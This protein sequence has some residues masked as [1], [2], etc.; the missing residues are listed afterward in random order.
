MVSGF[1]TS[2]FDHVRIWSAVASA[3]DSWAESFTS[4]TGA[5]FFFF[6]LRRDL[7]VLRQWCGL[8]GGLTTTLLV[9]LVGA[10][11]GPREVDAER[12]GRAER[13]LVELADLH[14]L[15]RFVH[16]A[17]VEAERLH[18][19]DEHLEALGDAGLGD[20]LALDDGLVDLHAS[21]HV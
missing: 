10:P 5:S 14:F 18:L 15:A 11:F 19:L 4:S 21:E 13:V 9:F 2:P 8:E 20:V 3:I 17:D 1:F 6:V 12:L 16:H 7:V